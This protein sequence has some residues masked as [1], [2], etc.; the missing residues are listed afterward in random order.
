MTYNL[1]IMVRV[2]IEMALLDG[3]LKVADL[4]DVWNAKMQE[5]LGVT[6]PDDVHGVLQ[7]I[8]WSG[9]GFGSFPGYTVGNVMSAQFL[10]SAHQQ[11]T[12]LD[13]SLARG[14]YAPLRG[15][16]TSQ[17]YRH[18][19]AFSGEELLV[20]ATGRPLETGPYLRYLT[21]KFSD[22]YQLPG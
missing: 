11:V 7:D 21:E 3:R 18:G 16:L 1:H 12:G 19:R 9:G 15:W 17:I 6:P 10:E 5:Y 22:L 14:D 2:E 8:H 13:K 20:R 4:P